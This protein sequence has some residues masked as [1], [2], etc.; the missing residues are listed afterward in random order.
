MAIFDTQSGF[1]Y[2]GTPGSTPACPN[3][4]APLPCTT[5]PSVFGRS[6]VAVSADGHAIA[7]LG[8]DASPGVG[9]LIGGSPGEQTKLFYQHLPAGKPRWTSDAAATNVS[10]FLSGNASVVRIS[11][12]GGRVLAAIDDATTFTVSGFTFDGSTLVKQFDFQ[13]SG[14]LYD[15]GVTSDLERIAIASSI[16][17]PGNQTH[18]ALWE[19]S[20]TTGQQLGTFYDRSVNGSAFYSA[21]V[22]PDGRLFAGNQRGQ[23]LYWNHTNDFVPLTLPGPATNVT[24][25]AL[26]ADGSRLG[27]AMGGALAMLDTTGTPALLWNASYAG[28]V[29]QLRLNRTGGMMVAAINGTNGGIYGFGD[30]DATPQWTIPGAADAVDVDAEADTIVYA[31]HSAVTVAKVPRLVSFELDGGGKVAPERSVKPGGSTTFALQVRNPGAALERVTFNGPRDTDVAIVADPPVVAV[32]AGQTEK[33]VVTATIGPSFGGRHAFNVTARALTC[34]C[35]DN[36]TLS[37]TLETSTD[38]GLVYNGTQLVTVAPGVRFDLFLGVQNNGTRDVPLGMSAIQQPSDGGEWSVALDPA[39][40]T[41]S[42]S[43]ITTVRASVTAPQGTPNGTADTVTFIMQGPDV[44]DQVQVTFQINPTLGV[45]LDAQGRVKFV[46]PGKIAFYNV[47]ATNTGSLGRDFEAFYQATPVGGKS[48]GVDM[49]TSPFHLDP[50]ASKT[51]PIRIFAPADAT[52][53][54]R[55]SLFVVVRSIPANA[56]ENVTT[57]NLTLFANA[58]PPQPTTTTPTGNVIPAPGAGALVACL[59]ILAI[60][61]RPRRRAP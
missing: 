58:I 14:T 37:L 23:I 4:P 32:D 3:T 52:P 53:S 15:V 29:T 12:D 28:T 16:P 39:T 35:F 24:P 13:Q 43:T 38:V 46:E 55:V 54:D 7:S 60:A 42:P 26:S 51:L 44:S 19:L 9:G 27:V 33:V 45:T 5:P 2:N 11:A 21:A 59:A 57:A 25:L 48:W 50:Q 8:L 34:A 18:A 20:F 10:V 1:V 49:D 47:T 30:L 6:R 17:E 31:Q 61:L 56:T 22:A 36:V 41:L 40:F